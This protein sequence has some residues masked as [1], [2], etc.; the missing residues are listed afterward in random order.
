MC[1]TLALPMH[2]Q[3]TL[4]DVELDGPT[5]RI[6]ERK[7]LEAPPGGHR[8]IDLERDLAAWTD[9][10]GFHLQ[11][12]VTSASPGP[13]EPLPV[14]HFENFAPMIHRVVLRD[15]VLFAGGFLKHVVH[16]V[17]FLTPHVAFGAIDL[18]RTPLEWTALPVSGEGRKRGAQVAE[19]FMIGSTLHMI[20]DVERPPQVHRYDVSQPRAPRS[21]PLIE[22]RLLFD[23]EVVI[24]FAV[25]ERAVALLW[26]R[27]GDYS[28]HRITLHDKDTLAQRGTFWSFP[29]QRGSPNDRRRL[30]PRHVAFAGDRLLVGARDAG[31]LVVDELYVHTLLDGKL[32]YED[33]D[34]LLLHEYA[35]RVPVAGG[36]V[37]QVFALPSMN[38]CLVGTLDAGGL[39]HTHVVDLAD[40][41]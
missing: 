38:H 30:S 10:T 32:T 34:N 25:G 35:R 37:L 4:C 24:E 23:G 31:V 3:L 5:P 7:R 33:P 15:G 13:I 12:G 21:L 29:P 20:D 19:L 9:N 27:D 11:R 22:L 18:D 2:D 40:A 6:V 8:A 39:A 1:L 26:Q 28:R 41:R 17:G 16:G 14:P 36:A